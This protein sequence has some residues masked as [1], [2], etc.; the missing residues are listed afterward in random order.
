MRFS[1]RSIVVSV[2]ALLLLAAPPRRRAAD[3]VRIWSVSRIEQGAG[4][5]PVRRARRSAASCRRRPSVGRVVFNLPLHAPYWYFLPRDRRVRQPV[6]ERRRRAVLGA[7]AGA[8]AEPAAGRG[9][10]GRGH[11]PGRVPGLREAGG[12][13]LA[14]DHALRPAAADDRRQQRALRGVGVPGPGSRATRCAPSCASMLARTPRRRAVTSSTAGGVAYLEG[15]QHSWRPGAATAADAPGPLWGE[16]DFDVDG[17]ADDS[18]TGAAG[19]MSLNKSRSV[20]VPLA[21]IP[22]GELFAVH[23]SLEAQAVDDRGGES[24]AQAFIQDPQHGERG[25]LLT[26]HGLKPRGKPRFKEPPLRS[27]PPARCPGGRPRDA[28]ALQFS[29]AGFTGN[30]SERGAAGPRHPHRRLARH[31]QRHTDRARRVGARRAR[32]SGRQQDGDLRRRRH[33]PAPG[34]GPAPRGPAGRAGGD[35][36]CRSGTRAAPRSAPSRAVGH[37]RRRRPGRA[38]RRRRARRLHDRRHGRRPPG[39][40]AR[41]LRTSATDFRSPRTGASRSPAPA[42]PATSYDVVVRTQPTTPTRSAP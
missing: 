35:V 40:G 22:R 41:A 33:V 24:A 39:A 3:P 29:D 2:G 34:R 7:G 1:F 32:T 26:A 17:D 30:E 19:V 15:H 14:A 6:L 38:G 25:L 31:R 11:A 9:A 36:Q 10:E 16:E 18:G 21:S 4:E 13:R 8:A 28:G 20:K 23:V 37:D 12:R 42:A 5:V 27:P